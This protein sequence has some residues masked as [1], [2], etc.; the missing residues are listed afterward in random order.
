MSY[1]TLKNYFFRELNK[2]EIWILRLD[3]HY[4]N[5][6]WGSHQMLQIQTP[7]MQFQSTV[8]FPW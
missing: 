5:T 4:K 6:F 1:V 7:P 8:K 3:D 2:A